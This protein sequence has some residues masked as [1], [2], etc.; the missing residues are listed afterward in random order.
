M[1]CAHPSLWNLEKSCAATSAIAAVG[2]TIALNR[3]VLVTRLLSGL[4][5]KHTTSPSQQAMG[6]RTSDAG[7]SQIRHSEV[8]GSVGLETIRL[9]LGG[10]STGY[11]LCH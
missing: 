4:Y 1:T 8:R 3:S 2:S 9:V 10:D 7:I 5:T 11:V 6:L